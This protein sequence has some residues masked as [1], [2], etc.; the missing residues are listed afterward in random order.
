[1]IPSAKL[2]LRD[3]KQADILA[4]AIEEFR[5]TGFAGA[6]INRI[7][8]RAHVSKRTLYKHYES[9]EALFYAII[10]LTIAEHQTAGRIVYD[11]GVPIEVQL[12]AALEAY[13]TKISSDAYMTLSRILVAEFLKD[14][15]ISDAIL[16]RF[17]GHNR[18]FA[19]LIG[20]AIA[21]GRLVP[22]DPDYAAT[23]LVALVKAFLFW[24]KFLMGEPLPAP[25]K[26]EAIIDD[27]IA[28][29]LKHYARD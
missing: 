16:E 4:A 21:D 3:R 29:F 6:R 15:E 24:P 22:V 12:K 8:E 1:M 17:E 23:Q 20:A 25:E 28:M 27:S 2:K 14:G 11:A 18:G 5:E 7:A 10:D 26:V 9:K 19:D 13:F